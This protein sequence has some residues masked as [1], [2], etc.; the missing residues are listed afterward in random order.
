MIDCKTV[1]AI[2]AVAIG[3]VSYIP[4]FKDIFAG[5]TKPHMFTWFIWAVLEGTAFFAQASKGAGAGAWVTGTTSILCLSVFVT[6]LSRGEK[7]I[8]TSDK[9]SLGGAIL[10]IVLW[11]FSKNALTAVILISITDFLGFIP[12]FKKSYFKPYEETAK[13]YVMSVIKLIFALFALKFFNLTTAL[14]PASLVLVNTA[15]VIMTV[16]RRKSLKISKP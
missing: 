11:Y 10:G 9:L 1:F 8:T 4:Y 12:T 3:F 6:S 16:I 5:R 14:Y 15:F 2:I 13:L 7:D